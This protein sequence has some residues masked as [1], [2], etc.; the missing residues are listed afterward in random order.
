MCETTLSST[1]AK[2]RMR[3]WAEAAPHL[4]RVPVS[5]PGYLKWVTPRRHTN[6][7][8]QQD[9]TSASLLL[10]KAEGTGLAPSVL[11][12]FYRCVVES[13]TCAVQHCSCSV[14]P[15][16]AFN[17]AGVLRKHLHHERC[18]TPHTWPACTSPVRQKVLQLPSKSHQTA[19]HQL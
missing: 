16:V 2:K 7:K 12:S 9:G 15:S 5:I 13:L 18:H 8:L 19:F 3:L 6:L 14:P 4:H 17:P 10:P 1:Q 11:A